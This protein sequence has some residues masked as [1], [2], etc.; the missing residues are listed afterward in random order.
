[1]SSG[2]DTTL[3]HLATTPN[4]AAV[5]MLLSALDSPAPSIQSGA[6]AS[7]L[8]RKS[9]AGHRE[10]LQRV[11]QLDES[12]KDIIREHPG[13]MAGALREAVLGSDEEKCQNAC[14]AILL[15][16]EFDLM[17][18]LISAAED[19]S[20]P[21][22]DLAAETV[23]ELAQLLYRELSGK[24]DYAKRRDPQLVR[25]HVVS[26]L[27]RSFARFPDH[28]RKESIEAFLMLTSRENA[29]L[30]K[31]LTNPRHPSFLAV[32][33][34]LTHSNQAGVI[35][36]LLSFLD[37]P[38]APSAAL[39]V[40]SHRTDFRF[41]NYLFKKV[42]FEPSA[43]AAR[44]LRRVESIAWASN[45]GLLNQLDDPGQHSAVQ[46]LMASGLKRLDKFPVVEYLAVHGKRGGRRAAV[47][48]LS[49]FSGDRAS[50]LLLE[51]LEDEDATVQAIALGRLRERGIP[52]AMTRLIEALDSPHKVVREAAR[53]SLDEFQFDRYVLIFDTLDDDEEREKTGLLVRKVD[54][55]CLPLLKLEMS[56][57]SRTRR[58]RAAAMSRAMQLAGQLE[59]QLLE[60]LEDEDHIVRGQAVLALS[61]C[62]SLEV[63]TA[64]A[65]ALDDPS[66]AVQ[67]AAQESFA[68]WQQNAGRV[69]SDNAT[70]DDER[71][72]WE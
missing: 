53:D 19:E 48:I 62:T 6:L 39:G 2:L 11:D 61:Q 37:D 1:M 15:F 30:Q 18:A 66:V 56:S 45:L 44:N 7:L 54:P 13:R 65:A 10:V 47:S 70:S 69:H 3:K 41:L 58:I 38:G 23:L 28:R 51:A 24:R 8:K 57:K 52:S 49:Q 67:E 36:L 32:V 43:S 46:M 17:P 64:L 16:H 40:L 9:L 59:K 26:S 42:G 27:E 4:E 50:Q 20:N 72:Q 5:D 68:L 71:S 29:S 25:R 14:R 21:N 63:G 33:D 22:V 55:N 35:R 12:C 60:L 34:V 31:V